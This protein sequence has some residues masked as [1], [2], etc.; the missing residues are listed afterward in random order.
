MTAPADEHEEG[1]TTHWQEEE[2]A[3]LT[4][5]RGQVL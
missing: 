1:A 2:A 4:G 5:Q 3:G